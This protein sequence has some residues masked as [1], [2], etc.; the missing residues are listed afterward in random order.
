MYLSGSMPNFTA[1]GREIWSTND[2]QFVRCDQIGCTKILTDPSS[3]Y[4]HKKIHT[5]DKRH[6]CPLCDSAFIQR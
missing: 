4:R 6:K 2:K 1:M 5:K 3:L